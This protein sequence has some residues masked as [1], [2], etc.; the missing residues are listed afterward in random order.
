[1]ISRFCFED[2]HKGKKKMAN[3]GTVGKNLT[4]VKK[5]LKVMNLK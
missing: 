4:A 5:E 3:A 2:S 1:L